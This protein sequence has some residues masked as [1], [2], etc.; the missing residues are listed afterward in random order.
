[1]IVN[2]DVDGHTITQKYRKTIRKTH[3]INNVLKIK[4]KLKPKFKFCRRPVFT[5]ACQRSN[6]PHWPWC[7][8][9]TCSK[10]CLLNC[11]KIRAGG[12]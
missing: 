11:N 3:K 4:R 7:I 9:F 12:V 5:F 6:S 8:V 10:L 1:M 2:P